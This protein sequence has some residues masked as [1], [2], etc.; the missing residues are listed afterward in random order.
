MEKE[1]I[2]KINTWIESENEDIKK[3]QA[4]ASSE[5]LFKVEKF[6]TWTI[7]DLYKSL[8]YKKYLVQLKDQIKSKGAKQG[9]LFF[10]K[11]LTEEV[12]S[13]PY[14]HSSTSVMTN[15]LKEWEHQV[16]CSLLDPMG[17][18]IAR[19]LEQVKDLSLF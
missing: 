7:E 8:L 14:N 1:I 18:K 19:L 17:G 13:Q 12:I 15:T 6:L 3:Y 2:A 11:R 4:Q 16:E 10:R 9:L 5:D